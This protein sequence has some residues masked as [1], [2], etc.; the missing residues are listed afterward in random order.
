VAA[1]LEPDGCF[2]VECFVPDLGRFDRGQ[3]VRAVEVS[4]DRVI[5]EYSIHDAANQHT[6][7][8]IE[9]RETDGG[10]EMLPVEVHY[11]FPDQIDAMATAA[12]LNLVERYEGYD[13]TPFTDVSPRHISLYRNGLSR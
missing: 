9:V 11:L 3:T 10:S 7:S 12:G 6:R 1:A 4:V 2:V 13:E 5:V 8:M